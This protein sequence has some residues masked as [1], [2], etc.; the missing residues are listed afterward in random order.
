MFSNINY[1]DDDEENKIL[2]I[3]LFCA[4]VNLMFSGM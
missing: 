4:Y 3:N 2:I 1:D